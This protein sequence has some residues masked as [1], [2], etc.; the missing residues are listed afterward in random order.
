MIKLNYLKALD[1]KKKY[2]VKKSL[3]QRFKAVT[4]SILMLVTLVGC[5]AQNVNT[6]D[7][8]YNSQVS[9]SQSVDD[10]TQSRLE[11][12]ERQVAELQ[13]ADPYAA[14]T[15]DDNFS[16][17]AW[18][19]F[20][21]E[22]KAAL[23]GKINNVDEE[24]MKAAFIILNIDYLND[25]AKQVLL[26]HYSQGQDIESEL[27]N[28]YSVLSQ[29]REHNLELTSADDYLSYTSIIK[30]EKD[31]AILAVLDGYAKE[32]IT[33]K[34]NPTD[35]NLQRIREIFDIVDNFSNGTGTIKV[36]INGTVEDIAQVDLTHGGIFAAE[37]IARY[38]SVNCKDIVSQ[39]KREALD[40]NLRSR[41][42]LAKTQETIIRYLGMASVHAPGVNAEAQEQ[43]V[44]NYNRQLEIIS[45][46]L[47]VMGVTQEEAQALFTIT[48]IDYFMD[49]ANSQYAFK[50]IYADGF[51]INDTFEKAGEAVRKIQEYNDK[52]T[53]VYDMAR[54]VMTSTADAISLKAFAQ[55]AHGIN[56]TDPD[57]VANTIH[58]VKGYSQ[59][60]SLATVDY[61]TVEDGQTVDH[62]IDKNGL[63]KGAY[64]VIN[65]Y[66]YYTVSNHKAT[67]GTTADAIL[68][69]VD[70]SQDGL[71]PYEQIV[72][73]VED[74]C[75]ENN[76][77]VYDYNVNEKTK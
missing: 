59:F 65:W 26:N 60:S 23:S 58:I 62:S 74:Y 11:E 75:A 19:A 29:V 46:E 51:A 28:L 76:I 45:N 71:N 63:S 54:L 30:D 68:P 41:N 53:Q 32:I 16:Q 22:C 27:N 21:V 39:E 6:Q 33:L 42:T 67:Y 64:Q 10:S 37:D 8:S 31:K 24:G 52:Q 12:L 7:D 70:G 47:A 34:Q 69:L 9:A 1:S 56:S 38:V 57:V 55:T 15:A 36:T 61:Q 17:E 49:G 35:E 48:N 72:L 43:I 73:M 13:N 5:G 40:E 4:A 3:S 50:V 25:N 18:D 77:V 66:T 14:I 2:K 44:N 20:V